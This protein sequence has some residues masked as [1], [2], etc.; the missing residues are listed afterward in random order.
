MYYFVLNPT[1]SSGM[2]SQVWKKIKP[3]LK[4]HNV[5]YTL[6]AL[7]EKEDLVTYVKTLTRRKVPVSLNDVPEETDVSK[8]QEENV[9]QDIHIVVLGGDGT[10]NLVLNS[11]EDMEHTKLSV[12]RVGSGNDFARNAGVD[13]SPEKALLHLLETPEELVLD[14][15]VAEYRTTGGQRIR[16]RFIIS[17]GIGYDADICEEVS[18]S[19][20]KKTLNVFHLGKLVYAMIGIKQIF[21]RNNT[22]AKIYMD[23]RKPIRV[24]NL[25]FAV[26]MI[27]EKEGGGVPFCPNADPCDGQL[28]IC[29]AKGA[30]IG[31][32][33]LEVLMV[34]W[35]KHLLFSN[36]A[37][38]RSRKI[39]VV[40][41][42]PQWIHLDG[43]TPGQVKEV[44]MTCKQGMKFVK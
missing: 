37:V 23:D 33:L 28:D 42:R 9:Q 8:M 11:I 32:Q 10:L 15:G 29:L 35:K 31:K 6:I 24:R 36:I 43:E 39:R 3:I 44:I 14:Y 12:I 2:G 20:L 27:H 25:F 34:Y 18:R 19:R 17:S 26:G 22:R 41:E 16:R 4:E 7:R 5:E 1:A 40:T 13:K 21:T 38:Y 30:F